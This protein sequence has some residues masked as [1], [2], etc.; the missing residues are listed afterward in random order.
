[1]DAIRLIDY[2]FSIIGALLGVGWIVLFYALRQNSAGVKETAA[3]VLT[4]SKAAAALVLL[5]KEKLATLVKTEHDKLVEQFTA[6]RIRVAEDYATI[7]MIEKIVEPVI[8]KLNEIE[9]MLNTKL[10]RREF[11]RHEQLR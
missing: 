4:E 1:M 3:L 10:D 6:F 9:V 7:N 5:E 8:K 2:L 11:E